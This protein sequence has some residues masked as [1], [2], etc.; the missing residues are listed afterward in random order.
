M[1]VKIRLT[2]LGARNRP[3]Y[4]IVVADARAPRDGRFKE[5]VGTYDPRTSPPNVELRGERIEHWLQQGAIPTRTVSEL[6]RHAKKAEST[7]VSES[8]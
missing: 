6:I 2:R 7:K 3:Y 8:E 4:R 5:V 1:A